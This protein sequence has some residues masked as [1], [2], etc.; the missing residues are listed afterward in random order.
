[1]RHWT[2]LAILAAGLGACST[3]EVLVPHSV[4]LVQPQS[5]YAEQQLLDIGVVLFDSGVPQGEVDRDLLEELLR[6]GTFVQIRR[7]EAVMLAVSLR[8]TLEKS[9]HW[10]SV[11]VTPRVSNAAD[12]NVAAEILQSDGHIVDLHVTATDASG[13]VWLDDNYDLETTAGAYNRQRYP[14]LDPYQDVYNEIANDLAALRAELSPEDVARIRSVAEL[15]YA[16]ELSPDAFDGYVEEQ[17]NGSFDV[18]RLPATDDP[19]LGRTRSV[20]QRERVFFETLD[21]YYE[22]FQLEASK[23]Y[24]GWREFSREDSIRLQEAARAAKLRTALGAL[25]IAMSIAYGSNNND[26]FADRV[27]ADAGIYI[28][29]DLLRAGA[30]RRQERMLY[31]QSLRELSESFD[32]DVKPLVVEIQGT[33]HRLTG[34]ADAQYDEWRQLLQQLF[35]SETGFVPEDIDVYTEPEPAPEAEAAP[36]GV[37]LPAE[38]EAAPAAEAQ[39]APA[40]EAE[41]APAAE[42]PATEAPASTN[43]ASNPGSGSE[44]EEAARD[45]GGGTEADA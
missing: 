16:N 21:T 29:G 4:A 34:T 44:A 8:E 32:D 31:T 37:P 10:G 13:H 33:Q 42:A 5:P 17:R 45:A 22:E 30:V 41:V 39:V 36:A 6:D 15:R 43:S 23:P 28:G 40:A 24:D 2:W 20:R 18:V 9:G 3:S 7:A 1:M 35:V 38:A 27:I 12:L 14:E 25:T 19:M 26:N 11:W